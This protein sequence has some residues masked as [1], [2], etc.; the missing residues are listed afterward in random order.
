MNVH[1][2]RYLLLA[3]LVMLA[4]AMT[5]W[6][7]FNTE[8]SVSVVVGAGTLIPALLVYACTKRT[9]NWSGIT[10]LIMIPYS[11]IGIMEVVATM[12]AIDAGM[13]V[14]ILGVANFFLALDAGRRVG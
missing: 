8:W 13:A 2:T 14:A 4:I 12:G 11:V 5:A 10:A 7:Q 6:L 9:R 1:S 3:G